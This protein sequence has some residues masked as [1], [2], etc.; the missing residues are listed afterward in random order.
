MRKYFLLGLALLGITSI[1]LGAC[2]A[3]D[4]QY[5][6]ADFQPSVIYLAPNSAAKESTQEA[7]DPKYPA[8]NF[9]P[10]VIF[11]DKQAANQSEEVFDPKYPAANFKPRIIYP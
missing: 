4:S 9:T 6:A 8:A 10:S 1:P 3:T 2:A 7:H 11:I 5:P